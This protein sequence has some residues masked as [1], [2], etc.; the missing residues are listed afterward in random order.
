MRKNKHQIGLMVLNAL[1][2]LML[3]GCGAN[4]GKSIKVTDQQR[5]KYDVLSVTGAI[6]ALEKRV[7]AAKQANMPFF[8]PNYFLEA[9]AILSEAQKSSAKKPKNVLISEVAKGD[10]LLDKGEEMMAVVQNRFAREI[11]LK[12]LLDKF[13]AVGIYPKEYEKVVGELSSLI[14]KV[15]LE[16][17]DKIDQDKDDLIKAMQSLDIKTVQYTALHVS[18]VINIDTK[19]KNGEKQAPATLAIALETY[20]RAENQI[21]QAP[22]DEEAVQRVGEEAMF[23]A[24][25]A[26]YVN[27]QVLSLQNQFKVSVEAIVLQH[28]K[29]LLDIATALDY[30]DLRDQ[31]IDKQAAELAMAASQ[32][33]Q[34]KA[35]ETQ[36]KAET[37]PLMPN[38]QIQELEKKLKEANDALE[39]ANALLADKDAQIKMLNVTITSMDGQGKA[40]VDSKSAET[41]TSKPLEEKAPDKPR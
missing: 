1:L 29:H 4:V 26:R 6:D 20:K 35:K 18:D 38:E 36:V 24:R 5:A 12:G 33:V 21:M 2:A 7:A 25:H 40:P 15:E 10:A 30:K 22:H 9:S 23:A 13:N 8:A 37:K 16:K 3:A 27:E 28:E 17:A 19:N 31:P 34:A 39:Q 14:E 41:E 32:L 11:E